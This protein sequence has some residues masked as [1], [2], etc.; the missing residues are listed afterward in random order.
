MK[1]LLHGQA[2]ETVLG[3]LTLE[4]SRTD[5][6]ATLTATL[7]T[8]MADRYFPKL[9]LAV[10]DGV[11]LV[12]EK[13]ENV[14]SGAIQILSY[15]PETVTLT[16]YDRGIYLARNEIYGVF[17]GSGAEIVR[18]VAGR[19]GMQVGAVD[20]P[21]TYQFLSAAVGETAFSLLRRVV[22][23]RR[24]IAMEGEKLC[25]TRRHGGT[26]ILDAT[27]LLTVENRVSIREMV[28]RSV[29]LRTNGTVAAQTEH[30]SDLRRY[31]QFQ[32]VGRLHG[33]AESPTEQAQLQL[34]GRTLLPRVSVWGDLALRCGGTAIL[35]QSQWGL[36]GEFLIVAAEHGGSGD[37]SPLH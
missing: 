5:A 22:G 3:R 11:R 36:N 21:A 33:K 6:A 4:K 37:F 17:A 25:V 15:T 8:A 2:V 18:A 10:G 16:A 30:P 28:N 20:A 23:K 35:Q 34:R 12:D 9:T 26:V 29:M 14:F 31:G 13:G 27:Q 32:A 1:L 24:E 19:L 7:Y